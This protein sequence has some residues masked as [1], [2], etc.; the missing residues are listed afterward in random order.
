STLPCP[1][2]RRHATIA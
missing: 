1:A 2:C